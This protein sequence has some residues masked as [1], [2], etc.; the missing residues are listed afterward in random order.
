MEAYLWYLKVQAIGQG[1]LWGWRML[2][3]SVQFQKFCSPL[4]FCNNFGTKNIL[5]IPSKKCP[6]V[7]GMLQINPGETESYSSRWVPALLIR[8]NS[9]LRGPKTQTEVSSL[10]KAFFCLCGEAG[11]LPRQARMP[12]GTS[13]D[14]SSCHCISFSSVPWG[15]APLSCFIAYLLP[16]PVHPDWFR[17]SI[18]KD[19]INTCAF[20]FAGHFW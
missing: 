5:S 3:A 6:S 15:A 17:T 7:I 2:S 4:I 19:L 11:M 8:W 16:N 10:L 9:N 13:G 20:V 18:V 12:A 14:N 1:S